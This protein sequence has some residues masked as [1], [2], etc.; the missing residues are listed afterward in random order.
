MSSSVPS[1]ATLLKRTD[2]DDHEEVLKAANTALKQ[3]KSDLEAQHVRVIALL[4]LDRYEDAA[5]AVEAGATGLKDKARLEYAYALYKSGKPTKAAEVAH[6]GSER[7]DK[8]VEAQSRYRTE[9]FGRAAEIYE[10]LASRLEDDAPL[11]LRV[12]GGAVD[13][14]LEWSGHGE[15]VKSKRPGRE[16][17]EAFETAY[18][19][20]CGSIARGEL[21]QGEVLLKRARD[22][23]SSL[24]DMS[25]EDKQVELLPIIVQQVYVLARLGRHEDAEKLSQEVD[26]AKI[27]DRSTRL[28]AQVNGVASSST[29]SNPFLAHRL[30]VQE[31]D[32]SKPDYPF[33]F[34][35]SILKQDRYAV[36]LQS[37]KFGGT[38][39]STAAILDR[40]ATPNLDAYHNSLSVINAAAHA[41]SATG[42]EALKHIL[43]LLEK[44]PTD[45]GLLLTILQLYI[46]T[47]NSGSA[48]QLFEGFLNR[49]EQSGTVSDLDVR[50]APGLIGAI[51]SLYHKERRK[52]HVQRELAKAATHWRR[53]S[54]PWPAGVVHLLKAAGSSL[55]QSSTSEHQKL[56][57]DIFT[58]LHEQD[59]E[60]RYAAAGLLAASSQSDTP[61]DTSILTPIDR[62]IS[63]IDTDA[64]ENTGIAQPPNRSGAQVIT[65]KR[66]AEDSKPKKPSKIRKTRMPKDHDPNKT[67]DP[68]RWLPLRD[69]STYRPKG[70]KG[71]ARANLL[72]QGAAPSGGAESEGSR[73]GTPGGEVVKGKQPPGGGGG[74]KKKGKGR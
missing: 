30:V 58:E 31:V 66:P 43:P 68:E 20:A 17:L 41:R 64:L 51:V 18:N 62:L 57:A 46:L 40:Q 47:G 32:H 23:C 73:P 1:L 59:P 36:D 67:P 8:H 33:Q 69:R 52:T 22:L 28:V 56:A 37:L 7:G 42:K 16:D 26:A 50:F 70:K 10:E 38:I 24:E 9:D 48:I 63:K 60:D 34:Q 27:A 4:K 49:L 25:E 5:K 21:A 55:L 14:Q 11:D 13:A 35:S 61:A 19:A 45:V 71:K 6:E 44:R 15:R 39:D 74:K 53:K 3:N 29:I 72:S 12:N 2:I 54:K 65:R